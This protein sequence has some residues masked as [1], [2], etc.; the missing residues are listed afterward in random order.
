MPRVLLISY[1]YPP[2]FSSGAIRPAALAKHLPQFGWEVVVLTP[3][4]KT[5][6]PRPAV[7]VIETGYEDVLQRWKGRV[8][9]NTQRGLHDQLS[10]PVAADPGKLHLHSRGIELLRQVLAFPD[11]H[12]GWLPHAV[13]ALATLR[14]QKRVDAILSTSPP[15]TCHLVA[16]EARR[17]LGCPWVAD[18][19]DLWARQNYFD[20]RRYLRPLHVRLEKHTLHTADAL[21]TVSPPWAQ[22]LL[23]AYPEKPV[24]VITNGFDPEDF[25]AARPPL[26]SMFTISHAGYLY[27]G[28]RD[29]SLLFEVL[30]DLVAEGLIDR[31]EV[32][33]RF[34]GQPEPWLPHLAR[35]YGVEEMMEACGRIPREEVLKRE[36]ESQVLLLLGWSDPR[37]VGQHTGK[38]FEYLGAGRP[39]LAVGGAEG[40]LTQTLTET[41]AGVHARNREQTRAALLQAYAEFKRDGAVSYHPDGTAIDRYT[42]QKMAKSFSEVLETSIG[43]ARSGCA[44]GVD[45]ECT[46]ALTR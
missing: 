6:S 2:R 9:M 7:E 37:E 27:D 11:E 29:P 21:V 45:R 34:Y 10:L 13:Q 31:R 23:E 5:A 32:R 22:R 1:H 33:V 35:R 3:K 17:I 4:Q 38:L 44:T 14:D 28:K 18:F 36:M 16:A 20:S 41:R 25:P 8:G 43:A 15:P 39:I 26:T 19:R 30:R 42:H 24:H 12:K 46:A 40:V